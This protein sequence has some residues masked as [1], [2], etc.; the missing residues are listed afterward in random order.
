MK[1]LPSLLT[2]QVSSETANT[3]FLCI[4]V[5]K[6]NSINILIYKHSWVLNWLSHPLKILSNL[7]THCGTW[8]YKPEIKSFMI[9]LSPPGSPIVHRWTS[10]CQK[11]LK[12]HAKFCLWFFF[13]FLGKRSIV[14]I[15]FY[16]RAKA[17]FDLIPLWQFPTH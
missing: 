3:V 8:T 13:S 16:K 11:F 10:G 2:T 7:D 14:F 15:S 4:P 12:F 17:F 6:C 9:W 5:V 1:S